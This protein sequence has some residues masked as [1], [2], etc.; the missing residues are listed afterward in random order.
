MARFAGFRRRGCG[1]KCVRELASLYDNIL[2]FYSLSDK[3]W[4]HGNPNLHAAVSRQKAINH[5]LLST[6]LRIRMRFGTKNSANSALFETDCAV[7]YAVES[8]NVSSNVR[9][10]R[11]NWTKYARLN[12][13]H[14]DECSVFQVIIQSS[15]KAKYRGRTNCHYISELNAGICP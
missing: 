10:I 6:F 2:I 15:Q 9:K 3:R 13:Y 8:S 1:E 7:K 11:T 12:F 14:R 5:N 4:P